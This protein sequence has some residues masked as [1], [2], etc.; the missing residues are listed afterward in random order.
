MA[1]HSNFDEYSYD[2]LSVSR[3]ILTHCD[4]ALSR[5]TLDPSKQR[6]LESMR[7]QLNQSDQEKRVTL[8]Y[9]DIKFL[10]SCL[11]ESCDENK[12]SSPHLYELMEMTSL[13]L[14]SPPSLDKSDAYVARMERLR[15]LAEE[16]EYQ[17]MTK[18]ISSA[19]EPNEGIGKELKVMDSQVTFLFNFILTVVG[20]FV[21][22]YKGVEYSLPTPNVSL[23]LT[24][25]VTLATIVFFADVYFIIKKYV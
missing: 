14:P 13:Q 2:M 21:F 1:V 23:Q 5:N 10:H 9:S 18:N 25:G 7:S 11:Q 16:A 19:S 3:D 8:K 6:K 24:V 22:G 12:E 17:K 20:A 15:L 4:T